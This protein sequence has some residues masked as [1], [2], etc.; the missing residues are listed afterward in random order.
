MTALVMVELTM[1]TEAVLEAWCAA[2]TTAFSLAS[3]IT[4]RTTAVRGRAPDRD[5]PQQHQFQQQQESGRS[6]LQ[7]RSAVGG[8]TRAGDAARQRVPVMLARE[9]VTD[10]LTAELTMATEAVELA[11]SVAAITVESSELTSMRKTTAVN[12]LAV[13]EVRLTYIFF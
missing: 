9:T 7:A 4:P 13:V 1:V 10:L 5:L 8:I 2:P 3:T 6:R 11:W 12:S